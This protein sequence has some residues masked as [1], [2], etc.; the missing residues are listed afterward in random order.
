MLMLMLML[1][2]PA[3]TLSSLSPRN[4]PWLLCTSAPSPSVL[5]MRRNTEHDPP[6]WRGPVWINVNYLALSALRFYSTQAGPHRG[7]AA[8][9]YRELRFNLVRNIVERYQESGYFWEQYD[10]T[11]DGKG[12]GAHPF[13]GWTALLVLIASDA[14]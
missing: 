14:S 12:K 5:Y 8:E 4:L 13:T 7:R 2:A 11:A 3:T 10:N 9:L 6:Y 1:A